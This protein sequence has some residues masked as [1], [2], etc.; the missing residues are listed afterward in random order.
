MDDAE[1]RNVVRKLMQRCDLLDA[2]YASL[3]YILAKKDPEEYTR[4]LE[5]AEAIGPKIT[6]TLAIISESRQR[7]YAAIEDANA[8]W[9]EAVNAWLDEKGPIIL[10]REQVHKIMESD[11]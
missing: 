7:A 1:T 3:C 10:S 5:A 11:I 4:T 9:Y 8:D 6:Q 2:Q